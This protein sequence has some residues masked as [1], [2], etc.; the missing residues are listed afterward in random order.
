MVHKCY[1]ILFAILTIGAQASRGQNAERP[2]ILLVIADDMGWGDMRS[3]GNEH[4]DT[5]VLDS[6]AAQSIEANHFYVSPVCAPTRASLLTGRYNL[7]THVSAVTRGAEV[8]RTEETTLA[9]TLRRAGYRTGIFGKWHL[10]EHYPYSPD[11]QGFDEVFGFREG[12]A[13]NYFDPVLEHNGKDVQTT[14]YITDVLT[15]AAL[16]FI[17]STS[18]EPFFAYVPYNAPHAPYQVE[19]A[20]YEKYKKQGFDDRTAI[21]YGMIE[22]MDEN[23]ARLLRK[24]ETSGLKE[25]TIVIFLTDNGP[26]SQR[27]NGGMKGTKGSVDE[28]GIRVP[29]LISW[30]DQLKGGR[31]IDEITAHID[32]MPTLLE[33][34]GFTTAA[35]EKM[36]FDGVSLMPLLKGNEDTWPDRMLFANSSFYEGGT[37]QGSVRTE[38]W[39]AVQNR[40][41]WE[42]YN[43]IDDPS[44]EKNVAHLHPEVVKALSTA[45]ANWLSEVTKGGFEVLPI[46]V[47]HDS[48]PV[49]Q[50]KSPDAK[51]SGNVQWSG[52]KGYAHEWLTNWSGGDSVQ[53]I[54]DVKHDGVY[55]VVL[56][57]GWDGEKDETLKVCVTADETICKDVNQHKFKISTTDKRPGGKPDALRWATSK[58]GT[59]KMKEGRRRITLHLLIDSPGEEFAVSGLSITTQRVKVGKNYGQVKE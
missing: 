40:E 19:Q 37:T 23:I 30:P 26:Q 28:G 7:R 33:A 13:Y 55:N 16:S 38:K 1:V 5:P 12:H 22:N 46:P 50:L 49:V 27:Y 10:G 32:I 2:N 43:M 47:G 31:K 17:S 3:H 14:G 8:M 39:R 42:L 24:L 57:Y 20:Y 52:G 45:Y 11:A 36:P 6:L 58:L 53:W 48:A 15:D 9:E 41:E 44:Q 59:V 34:A 35:I 54:V 29:F 4:I 25:N 56:H 18:E 51:L 21:I